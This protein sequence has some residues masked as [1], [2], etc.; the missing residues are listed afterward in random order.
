M[1]RT[2]LSDYLVSG[3]R[4]F[5]GVNLARTTAAAALLKADDL[6][7]DGYMDVRIS[8][9]RGQVL[10]SDD[11]DQREASASAVPVHQQVD[12]VIVSATNQGER[13]GKRRAEK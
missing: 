4:E 1:D 11:L 3:K 10:P 6:L 7:Q 8:T 12:V 2:V 5:G 13:H 9:P